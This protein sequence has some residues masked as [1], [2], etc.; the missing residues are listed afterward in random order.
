M[1]ET[2]GLILKFLEEHAILLLCDLSN[3]DILIGKKGTAKI[4]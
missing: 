3:S 2:T 4:A 1:H